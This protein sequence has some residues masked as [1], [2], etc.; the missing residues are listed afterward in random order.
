MQLITSRETAIAKQC[1][2]AGDK[3]RALL[4][5]RR[6]KYQ[7]SMLSRTDTQ[8]ETLQQLTS[9]VEFA[10][11]QKDVIFGLKQGTEVLRTIQ[12][13]MGGIEEVEK[14]L[15]DGEEQRAWQREVGDMLAGSISRAEDDE[16]EE[17]LEGLEKELGITTTKTSSTEPAP[18]PDAPSGDF[19]ERQMGKDAVE[20]SD[21]EST[22]G[23]ESQ[24]AEP[25]LA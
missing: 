19:A 8:L 10:L 9:N 11:V 1:L 21:G 13:E 23:K 25:M 4:A 6:K 15:G 12:K 3:P 16:V 5:L 18:L 24:A 2:A 7:E 14:I 17:E 22:K 20:K